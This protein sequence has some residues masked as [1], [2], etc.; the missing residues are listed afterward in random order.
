MANKRRTNPPTDVNTNLRHGAA[1]TW[2]EESGIPSPETY[3][4]LRQRLDSYRAT[5]QDHGTM[6]RRLIAAVLEGTDADIAA[7]RAQ[8][9]GE[10]AGSASQ[11]TLVAS[12]TAPFEVDQAVSTAGAQ[13]LREIYDEFAPTGYGLIGKRFDD[14]A[15]RFTAAVKIVD[16][17]ARAEEVIERDAKVHQ[18]WREGQALAAELDEL[19]GLVMNAGMLCG[20]VQPAK[21]QPSASPAWR[22]GWKQLRL[23]LC[24]DADGLHRRRVWQAAGDWDAPDWA[25]LVEVGATL[26][27]VALD[28]YQP[29]AP[30]QQMMER[31]R[32]DGTVE[33]VDPHDGE[34][35][36]RPE[37]DTVG[38]WKPATLPGAI[39]DP[40]EVHSHR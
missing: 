33:L 32:T 3:T 6:T 36:P 14:A 7:L 2:A 13:R 9:A 20:L 8:A 24:C 39:A 11:G 1:V 25:A 27:V 35:P 37:D 38:A 26:R 23:G 21:G 5:I 34:L 19:S 31:R 28:Q 18:K 22:D 12:G 30:P 29:Y 17:R 15:K 10:N 4:A 16:P 40:L